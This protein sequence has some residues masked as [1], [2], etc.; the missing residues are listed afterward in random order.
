MI[1]ALIGPIANLAGTW[2]QNKLEK[3][4]AE[5]KAKVAE[6]KA[7]ATVAEKVASGKI[8][9]EGKMADA[10][11]DSWKDEFALVVLLAP[12]ILV[13]IPGM[14]EYV[15]RGFEMLAN[16]QGFDITHHPAMALPCGMSDGLPVSLQLVGKHFNESTIYQ[17]AH[18]FQEGTDWKNM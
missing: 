13:F 12:A 4:K 2:F 5:G 6:A 15:Q 10:T 9:W 11:N 1:Q 16:T 14:R 17:A 7:R 8:E 3:T 18:G